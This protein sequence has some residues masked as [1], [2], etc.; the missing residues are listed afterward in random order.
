MYSLRFEDRWK[1]SDILNSN[2]KW[3]F[4]RGREVEIGEEMGGIE[5]VMGV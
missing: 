4:E 1:G 5:Y 2:G 3:G